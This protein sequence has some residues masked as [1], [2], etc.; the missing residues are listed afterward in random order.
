MS[1]TAV[2]VP[3]TF[4][5]QSGTIQLAL[6][7][8]NFTPLANALNALSQYSNYFLDTSGA[9]N[10]ITVTVAAPL[11]FGYTAGIALQVK[12]ANT[13]TSGT[14]VINVNTLGNK[15]VVNPDGSNPGVGQLKIGGI[16]TLQF[17]GSNFQIIGASS[18][19]GTIGLFADGTNLLPSISFQSDP[20]TGIYKAGTDII[21]ITTAGTQRVTVN[22]TGN[23]AV[24]AP[25]SGA[26]VIASNIA[27]QN[28]FQFG[29]GTR[30]GFLTTG[31]GGV[32]VGS[33]SADPLNLFTGGSIRI[34]TSAAGNVTFNA[35]SSGN[36][37][38]ATGI[39]TGIAVN[40]TGSSTTG[41][42]F[43]I[44]SSAG[45]NASDYGLLVT[46]QAGTTPWFK[47]R[48]DGV[49]FG[50][51]GTNLF[52]LGYKDSPLNTPG[53]NYTLV[54]SDRGKTIFVSNATTI[55]IP[56]GV[57]S[58]GAVVSF[59]II[60]PNAATIAQGAGVTLQW[61]GNGGTTGNRTFTGAGL[62]TVEFVSGSTAIIS[63]GGLS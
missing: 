56:N 57:F 31:T 19:S 53:A 3:N 26:S 15:S 55:T 52:E 27:G 39:A 45:T 54:A 44:N 49:V 29:D 33:S 22:A 8:Q 38:Q 61:S 50:N 35:P 32:G 24:N 34:A 47:V 21:G 28:A 41:Q 12:I 7:D 2:T 58:G 1:N 23:V 36:T 4:A 43:G 48:G 5:N 6:L 30:V 18:V 17:D 9:A 59:A 62:A 20:T 63:G 51:D 25:S 37:I 13:N 11:T 60:S 14:V 10:A 42:S 40:A 16:Y 46:N